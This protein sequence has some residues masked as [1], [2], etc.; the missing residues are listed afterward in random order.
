MSNEPHPRP[1][2]PSPAAEPASTGFKA[3]GL[4]G[5]AGLGL[6]IALPLLS[7]PSGSG[8]QPMVLAATAVLGTAL[9]ILSA[10][11]FETRRLPDSLTL[12]LMAM[13]LAAALA[14][15]REGPDWAVLGWRI[16]SAGSGYLMLWGVAKA[17]LALKGRPGLGLGDAKLMAAGGAWLGIEGLPTVLLVASVAALLLVAGAVLRGQKITAKTSLPFGPFL[18]L[19]IWLVWLYGPIA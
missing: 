10:I 15:D 1:A 17:Y 19:G 5:F 9:A 8:M 16:L 12:P 3:S 7:S 18:A 2:R 13:G 11:D 6:V 4:A 14:L